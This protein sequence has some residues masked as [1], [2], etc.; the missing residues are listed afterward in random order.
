MRA[1]VA[2]DLSD[3]AFDFERVVWPVVRRWMGGGELRPVEAVVH[4]GFDKDLDTLS[5][6]DGWHILREEHAIRGIASR[7]QPVGDGEKRWDT[8]TIRYS[9]PSGSPT[10]YQ[11]R[12][13]ALQNAE[14]GFLLPHITTQAYVAK[15]SR[16]GRL[17]SVAMLRTSV[18]YHEAERLVS[19]GLAGEVKRW[20]F[21]RTYSGEKLLWLSW[22]LFDPRD[23]K[24]WRIEEDTQR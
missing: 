14:R 3:S 23:V 13:H 11:K 16:Q 4:S 12:L 22:D 24:I 10:E 5:G 8:F 9:R 17:L 15:P 18:L 2:Q 6:I 19:S 21:R 1:D 7:V 20:G